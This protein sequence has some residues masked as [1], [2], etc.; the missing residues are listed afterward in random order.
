MEVA[1][2][3]D[4]AMGPALRFDEIRDD[5][6]L[7]AR[8]QVVTEH[9]PVFGDI[10]TLGNPIVV[11]GETFTISSAPSHGEHT[12]ELLAELGYDESARAELRAAGVV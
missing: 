6:H 5:P 8:G 10:L 11:P 12:D 2:E 4:I 9:H 3:H 1:I 7:Q